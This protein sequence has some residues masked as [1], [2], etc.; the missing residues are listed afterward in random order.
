MH[1]SGGDGQAGI[2][3]WAV[4]G[5][6]KVDDREGGWRGEHEAV[7][8]GALGEAFPFGNFSLN[9]F[10]QLGDFHGEQAI[11]GRSLPVFDGLGFNFFKGRQSVGRALIKEDEDGSGFVRIDRRAPF[12]FGEFAS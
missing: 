5:F 10:A 9:G 3:I 6:G 12:F 1:A 4:E 7:G 8:L 2:F 11:A